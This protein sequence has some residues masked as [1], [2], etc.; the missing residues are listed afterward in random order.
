MVYW[1][2]AMKKIFVASFLL[3]NVCILIGFDAFA[4][5][6]DPELDVPC[7]SFDL[8]FIETYDEDSPS[9]DCWTISPGGEDNWSIGNFF[10]PTASIS[11]PPNAFFV[12]NPSKTNYSFSFISPLIDGTGHSEITLDFILL[13]N[14]F[15]SNTPEQMSVEYKRVEDDMWLLLENFNSSAADIQFINEYVRSGVPLPGMAGGFFQIRFRAHGLNTFTLNGWGIDDIVIQ[16]S[17]ACPS[18]PQKTQPGICGCGVADTDSD[19]DGIPDCEDLCPADAAKS[20]PGVCGCGV[21]DVDT[22]GDGI[23]DCN[24]LCPNDPNKDDPGICGCGNADTD[25]DSLCPDDPNKTEP[26]I[27]GCGT[28][29]TDSDSDGTPDCIDSCPLDPDKILAG[30]CGCGVPDTDSLGLGIPDCIADIARDSCTTNTTAALSFAIDGAALNLRQQIIVAS[31]LGKKIAERSSCQEIARPRIKANRQ[32]ATATYNSIWTSAWNGFPSLEFK[33]ASTIAAEICDQVALEPLK[34]S[35][36]VSGKNIARS[37]RTTLSRCAKKTRQG[38]KF[39]RRLK[40]D[41]IREYEK[42]VK[43]LPDS[44]TMCADVLK[45]N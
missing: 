42:S 33:C 24:D 16:G 6:I 4:Q 17:D 41:Y 5:D 25:C 37:I 39:M 13:L 9:V 19:G 11:G 29:D 26:G 28:P 21:S 31:R 38:R 10:A 44:M 18:D 8:P 20:D 7:S 15:F 34:A 30:Q 40:R 12:W 14:L 23:A 22:D 1:F 43:A 32:K 45:K 35:M 3:F 36:L 27:C 2:V